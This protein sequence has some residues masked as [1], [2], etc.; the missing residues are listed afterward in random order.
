MNLTTQDTPDYWPVQ[1]PDAC[2]CHDSKL[3]HEA[4]ETATRLAKLPGSVAARIAL[5]DGPCRWLGTPPY[6]KDGYAR[7]AGRGLH[8]VVWEH[9]NGPVP[10]PLVLDHVAKRGCE[11]RACCW[12]PHLEVVTVRTNILRGTSFAAVNFAKTHCGAC[13]EGYSIY[14][15]YVYRGRRD[16]RACIRRR[17]RE[18]KARLRLAEQLGL[19]A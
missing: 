2:P 13:G 11:S 14:N 15:T 12:L 6:D 1:N 16:C 4:D 3:D 18:Y 5:S 10:A 19:A 9:E 17:V 7:F 8:R